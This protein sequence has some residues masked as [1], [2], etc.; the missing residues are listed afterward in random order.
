M[1]ENRDLVM[2]WRAATMKVTDHFRDDQRSLSRHYQGLIWEFFEVFETNGPEAEEK[3][4]AML[5]QLCNDATDLSLLMRKAKD[6]FFVQHMHETV[7]KLISEYE[8]TVE[9]EVSEPIGSR[10][11]QAQTV[12]YILAGALV[13]VSKENPKENQVLEPAQAVVYN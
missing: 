7:G 10:D 2:E 1:L 8:A 6:Q 12:A 11:L 3:G 4:K 5:E 13:K 9:E